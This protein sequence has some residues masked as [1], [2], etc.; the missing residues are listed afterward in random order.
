MRSGI[1]VISTKKGNL[2]KPVAGNLV[3]K[4]R[5]LRKLGERT[6]TSRNKL[7]KVTMKCIATKPN[8][9]SQ[10]IAKHRKAVVDFL[11]RD[12]NSRNMPKK[13]RQ[14]KKIK[15]RKETKENSYRL[16]VKLLSKVVSENPGIEL[17]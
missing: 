1:R 17:S 13:S 12:D 3:K 6:G 11:E 14:P 16:F 7:A 5:L 9:R 2:T 15:R 4:Y 8:S 10:V